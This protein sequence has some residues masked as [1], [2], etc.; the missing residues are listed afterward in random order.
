MRKRKE[1]KEEYERK[2]NVDDLTLEALLDI[3]DLLD[4]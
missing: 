3:R 2:G 4:K 1:I